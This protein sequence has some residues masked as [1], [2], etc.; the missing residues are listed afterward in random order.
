M[1]VKIGF[2]REDKK[3]AMVF[4][5]GVLRKTF[6]P[7]RDDLTG[8]WRE[9]HIAKGHSLYCLP[10]IITR[11]IKRWKMRWARHVTRVMGR[12]YIHGFVENMKKI[13]TWK[14]QK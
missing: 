13:Y 4:E 6:S 3:S 8:E 10:D 2:S 14:T 9:L 7:E 11:V 5:N 1:S 12:D